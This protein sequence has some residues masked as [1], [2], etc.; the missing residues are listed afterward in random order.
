MI[1]NW[2]WWV[3]TVC[4]T[5]P[6]VENVGPVPSKAV[7]AQSYIIAQL[8]VVLQWDLR[9]GTHLA[10]RKPQQQWTL[11]SSS[12]FCSS[13][14]VCPEES[15]S[16][17][18]KVQPTLTELHIICIAVTPAYCYMVTSYQPAYI[19]EIITAQWLELPPSSIQSVEISHQQ[20]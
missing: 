11:I 20:K 8:P 14:L 3:M 15:V 9:A 4:D 17:S 19:T 16:A 12:G 2:E 18:R 10:T 5:A 6:C 1:S 7:L 13:S